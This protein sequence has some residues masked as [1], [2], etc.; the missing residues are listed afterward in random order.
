MDASIARWSRTLG[1]ALML[2]LTV[3][4]CGTVSVGPA[5][6]APSQACCQPL[7]AGAIMTLAMASAHD[8]WAWTANPTGILRTTNGAL[9][10]RNVIPPGPGAGCPRPRHPR[11][12]VSTGAK[13]GVWPVSQ[14]PKGV[15]KVGDPRHA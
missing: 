3:T 15:P 13:R 2:E 8:G 7:P 14:H 9:T 4:A 1:L 6:A 11:L 5:R 12:W 10:W